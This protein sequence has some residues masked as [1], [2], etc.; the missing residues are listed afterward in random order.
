MVLPGEVVRTRPLISQAPSSQWLGSL[1]NGKYWEELRQALR[2][3]RAHDLPQARALRRFGTGAVMGDLAGFALV[4]RD[5]DDVPPLN[6]SQA[7][8]Y[9]SQGGVVYPD[10]HMWHIG[11][12]GTTYQK[13]SGG[14]V[15]PV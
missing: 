1:G 13:S 11:P 14:G 2:S 5:K 15:W 3:L 10:R 4:V 9:V 12:T 8:T 6:G 7:T